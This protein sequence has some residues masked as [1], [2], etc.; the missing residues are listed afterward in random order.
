MRFKT[1]LALL[2]LLLLSAAQITRA[3]EARLLRFP[4]IHE[5]QVIFVYAG[6][7]WTVAANGGMARKITSF[8]GL[9]SYPK[10]SPNGKS[11]AF[12]AAYDGNNDVFTIPS[13]GGEPKRLTFHPGTDKVVEWLPDGKNIAFLSRRESFSY[14]FSRLFKIPADG[15]APESLPLPTAGLASF[16]ADGKKMAYNRMERENRT[17][18][19]YVGGMAQDIWIYDL[20]KNEIEQMTEFEG[21][22]NFPMWT[23]DKIYFV[24]DRSHTANI[25]CYDLKTK[26]TRQITKFDEYDVKWPSLGKKA[27]VF[28][29]GGYLYKLDLATEKSSK[30]KVELYDDKP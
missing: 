14:R 29:N 3:D 5:N 1:V 18:K 7:L 9:E 4:D 2:C 16:S 6:D 25:F 8:E 10:F 13:Q 21:T 12:T 19:R 22:D 30:I 28:E 17:W 20:A 15:T 23:G 24:S 27:I 26:A 11:I